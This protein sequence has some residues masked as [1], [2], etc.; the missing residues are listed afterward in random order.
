MSNRVV[1]IDGPSASGKSTVARKVAAKLGCLYVDSG[2]VYRAVTWMALQKGL[3]SDIPA[4]KTLVEKLKFECFVKDGAVKFRMDGQ[5][6]NSELRSDTVNENV[7]VISAIPEVRTRVVGW[8]RGMQEFGSLVI[9]GR[10]IGTAV[11]PQA[12]F[13]FYLDADPNERA[14]RRSAEIAGSGRK[15]EVSAVRDSLGRRDKIDSSRKKDPL[16][17]APEAVVVDTTA[18]TI[19]DVADLIVGKTRGC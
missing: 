2:A 7:S 13:K 18:M 10:D 16:K 11:F 12:E 6:L 8:L 3:A 9:E 15:T 5:E 14:R 1:A 4:C 19:E 17:I